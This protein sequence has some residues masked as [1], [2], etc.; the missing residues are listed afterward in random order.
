MGGG[1]GGGGGAEQVQSAYE[2][3]NFLLV[4]QLL[5]KLV[6][7]DLSSF[8]FE[9]SKVGL[10]CTSL[11]WGKGEGGIASDKD[12]SA[13]LRSSPLR[14]DL[15]GRTP[16]TPMSGRLSRNGPRARCCGMCTGR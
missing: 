11:A 3:Y 16:C 9:I 5:L 1:G 14:D 8:Y 7:V 12:C 10:G 6:G 4:T 13:R 15:G 2:D